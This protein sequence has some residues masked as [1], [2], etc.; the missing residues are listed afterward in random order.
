M[1]VGSENATASDVL[2]YRYVVREIGQTSTSIVD[3]CRVGLVAC[4]S[5]MFVIVTLYSLIFQHGFGH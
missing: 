5:S 3:A 4:N 2:L 1:F